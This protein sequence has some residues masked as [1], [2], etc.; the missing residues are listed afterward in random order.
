M[1]IHIADATGN[2]TLCHNGIR[3][4]E[5]H[6]PAPSL[7]Q[8]YVIGFAEPGIEIIGNNLSLRE[9]LSEIFHRSVIGLI[10]NHKY[11]RIGNRPQ[12]GVEALLNVVP[13]LIADY[14]D[15]YCRHYQ[16]K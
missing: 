1:F 3:V 4:K 14:D 12:N 10:V 16:S 9:S 7:G 13:H 2:G 6:I 15:T 11:L 5:Q 8:S